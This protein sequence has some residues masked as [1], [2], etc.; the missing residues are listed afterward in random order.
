MGLLSKLKESFSRGIKNVKE[1]PRGI[2][3]AI[4][5][6]QVNKIQQQIDLQNEDVRNHV[7]KRIRQE[8]DPVKRSKLSKILTTVQSPNVM[9]EVNP[10]AMN[11]DY[12]KRV[13]GTFFDVG[14]ALA[15]PAA[16]LGQGALSRFAARGVLPKL[17][18]YSGL[19]GAEGAAYQTGRDLSTERRIDP[20]AILA[21]GLVGAVGNT[22]LSPRLIKGSRP[23]LLSTAETKLQSQA[24][25][26][27]LRNQSP[28]LLRSPSQSFESS[29]PPARDF[30]TSFSNWIGKRDAA[31]TTSTVLADKLNQ[32]PKQLHKEIIAGLEGKPVSQAADGFISKFR[33]QYDQLFN[34]A[35]RVG[36]DLG[37]L[38]NYVTHIWEKPADQVAQA[39]QVAKRKFGFSGDRLVPT[40]EEGLKMGLRPKYTNPAQIVGEY[41]RKL[42]ETKANINFLDEL[43]ANGDLVPVEQGRRLPGYKPVYAEGIGGNWSAP[44]EVADKINKIFSPES[45]GTFGK[46]AAIGAKIS[47]GAQDILMSGGLPATPINAF[48]IA[49]T[50]KE[51]M[52]GRVKSPLVSA[53]RSLSPGKSREFFANNAAQIK[54]LQERGVAINSNFDLQSLGEATGIK[55]QLGN[56]W[57]KVVNE[58]T[59]KRFMPMLQVNLFNDIEKAAM[60]AGKSADE[61][62]TIGAQAVK[63]FYGITDTAKT[64]SRGQTSKDIVSSLFFA[65]RYRE[66]MI[67]FWVNNIKALKDPLALENRSNTMFGVSAILT[68]LAMDHA[69]ASINGHGM[70]DNP[71]GK[72]DKLLIPIGGGKTIGIPFLS[73]IATVPR[74][75][76]KAGKAAIEGDGKRVGKELSSN[77]SIALRP[78]TDV[79][80]NENYFGNEIYNEND[81]LAGKAKAGANYLLNPVTGAFTHPYLREGT[82][83][84]QG[85]QGVTETLSKATE[86]PIRWYNTKSIEAAPF[87]KEYE[88]QKKIK[89]IIQDVKYGKL[90][91]ESADKKLAKLAGKTSV[92]I[93]TM[94]EGKEYV[95]YKTSKGIAFAD[96]K[97]QAELAIAKDKFKQSGKLTETFKDSVFKL[98]KDGSVR[99]VS[100]AEYEA[101]INKPKKAKVT[102]L[103]KAKKAKA[104]KTISTPKF[105]VKSARYTAPQPRITSLSKIKLTVPVNPSKLKKSGPGLTAVSG[106]KIKIRK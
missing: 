57:S 6:P 39:Y 1:L 51:V 72:E 60:K 47:G 13:G 30:K 38:E 68:Y 25:P 42:E 99:T 11:Q 76:Y 12:A 48:T 19:R 26:V 20:K 58:P 56:V 45:A 29:I 88:N 89:E 94:I 66:S 16:G 52:G 98:N 74:S 40:Y 14:T 101:S 70:K 36:V 95:A 79:I 23:N 15:A 102:K 97:D 106:R 28:D 34:E 27:P 8:P 44:A 18:A 91:Q 63:N 96:N 105:T 35:K 49:Q 64:A 77:L 87:W 4:Y 78:I 17:A 32:A 86:L 82:K 80:G 53:F 41:A 83:F 21:A 24:P 3:T 43:K 69:N 5:A 33:Q 73:S 2:A 84:A 9:Q 22:L 37:Y 67:N 65:P 81:T 10:Q 92:P 50:T 46:G 7:L 61:A 104:P 75:L 71:E 55:N 62:A 90:S 93:G 100:K 59:F 85:K 54:K 31:R 103:K